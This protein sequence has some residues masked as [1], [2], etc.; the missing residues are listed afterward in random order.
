MTSG[1]AMYIPDISSGSWQ[2][3]QTPLRAFQAILTIF[4]GNVKHPSETLV[5]F[6]DIQTGV[7]GRLP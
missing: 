4:G 1:H 5:E 7:H 3:D 6:V 2:S